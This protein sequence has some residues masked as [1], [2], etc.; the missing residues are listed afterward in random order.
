MI[1]TEIEAPV[2]ITATALGD[3]TAI[4]PNTTINAVV[5]S[6]NADHIVTIPIPPRV[7]YEL[8]LIVGANGCE[9]RGPAGGGVKI[10][11]VIVSGTNEAAIPADT[12]C[13]LKAI[14]LTNYNLLCLTKLGA[15]VAAIVPDA[16]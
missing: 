1:A 4:V 6:A 14:S 16:V 15:V 2:A 5:T 13:R 10:N 8:F 7:G 12:L 9:L 11:D 3:G